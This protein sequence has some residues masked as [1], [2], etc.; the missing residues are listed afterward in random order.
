M[1][2]IITILGDQLVTTTLAIAEG[3]GN[4]HKSVLE[5]IRNNLADFE[6]FGRV[7]FESQPFKTAGGTQYR[8][9]G[10]L[11]EQQATLALTYMRNSDNVRTFKKRLVKDFWEM[12]SRQVAPRELSTMDILKI[13]M[14]SEQGR[15]L[16]IEQR[17]HAIAT[18]AQIGSKREASAMA[19]ASAAVREVAKLKSLIG[20][21]PASA[22]ILAVQNKTGITSF[23]WQKLKNYCAT[24]GLIMKK[25][26]NPGLQLDVNTCPAEAWH[27]VY[28]I[29][30]QELFGTRWAA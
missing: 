4:Q 26:F 29:D 24:K 7:A 5:L 18:K 15:L 17:D 19:T 16:A 12:R 30:I 20:E 27:E 28:G 13:S 23:Q 22:S 10:I 21:A 11:N 14:E 8:E 1:S 25:A 9:V 3:T 6:E 2:S